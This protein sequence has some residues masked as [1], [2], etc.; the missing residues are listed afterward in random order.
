ME[1][2]I[3]IEMR[4]H[5]VY[6]LLYTST[7]LQWSPARPIELL[8]ICEIPILRY[9]FAR[10]ANYLLP[11]HVVLIYNYNPLISRYISD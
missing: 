7:T 4:H 3:L 6:I 11:L 1:L 5:M 8:T 10:Y 9:V 2:N